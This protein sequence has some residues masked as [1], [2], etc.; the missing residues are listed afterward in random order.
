MCERIWPFCM[1]KIYFF[2][3]TKNMRQNSKRFERDSSLYFLSEMDG[4]FA[5]KT[6]EI[7]KIQLKICKKLDMFI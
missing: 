5:S 4:N 2:P 6:F 7:T 3:V 1:N